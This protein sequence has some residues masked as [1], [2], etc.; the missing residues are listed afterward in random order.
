M[1]SYNDNAM[2]TLLNLDALCCIPECSIDIY[3]KT[4]Y[5]V[6]RQLAFAYTQMFDIYMDITDD[7]D[8]AIWEKITESVLVKY[9]KLSMFQSHWYLKYNMHVDDTEAVMPLISTVYG[10]FKRFDHIVLK[11]LKFSEHY[12]NKLEDGIL[13]NN[14]S[15]ATILMIIDTLKIEHNTML[16]IELRNTFHVHENSPT[17]NVWKALV[18]G[19]FDMQDLMEL[20]L[21]DM[22]DLILTIEHGCAK[23]RNAIPN[24]FMWSDTRIYSLVQTETTMYEL[25]HIVEWEGQDVRRNLR[26]IIHAKG[27]RC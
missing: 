15:K 18:A 8:I 10:N 27:K 5:S 26:P 13:Y 1:T 2:S 25:S 4:V 20:S 6:S 14:L 11:F 3:D 21:E 12:A 22:Q 17:V 24:N 19:G 9:K 7:N 16:M 23:V